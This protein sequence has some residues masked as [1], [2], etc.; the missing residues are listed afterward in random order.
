VIISRRENTFTAET[1]DVCEIKEKKEKKKRKKDYEKPFR[2][3]RI[4][5][6][7]NDVRY[8]LHLIIKFVSRG[9]RQYH[10]REYTHEFVYSRIDFANAIFFIL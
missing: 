9:A 3:F 5:Y 2:I 1:L 8:Q 7:A 4:H 6:F 10:I